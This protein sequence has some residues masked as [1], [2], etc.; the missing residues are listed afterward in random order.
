MNIRGF[1]AVLVLVLVIVYALWM[2]KIGKKSGELIE[3]EKYDR[4]RVELTRVNMA[5]VEKAILTFLA[6]EGRTPSDLR[7][8]QTSRI[9]LGEFADA[10]GR[11]LIYERLS[12][13]SFRLTSPG[14]DGV[15]D[16]E[17]DI[18]IVR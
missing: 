9:L 15:L 18:V 1:L 8:L 14:E 3:K 10:W 4:V 6:S 12:E 11:K 13:A 2:A 16:S 7:E 5:S 17:D